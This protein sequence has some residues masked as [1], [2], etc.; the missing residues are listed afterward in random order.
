MGKAFQAKKTAY[1]KA[2]RYDRIEEIKRS[3][4]QQS[5]ATILEALGGEAGKEKNC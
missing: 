2:P 5:T 3:S 4:K 1:A